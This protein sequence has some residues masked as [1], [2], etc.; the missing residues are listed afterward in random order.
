[1]GLDTTHN[2]WHGAYS[3][4]MRWREAVCEVAGYGDIHKRQGFG[5]CKPWPTKDALV[6][7]LNHSDCDGEIASKD[8]APLADRLEQLL[9]ALRNKGVEHAER[10][11]DFI[12]G[13]RLAAARGEDVEFR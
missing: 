2:C 12:K 4:F 5:G 6:I 13:L 7:L 1:M 11:E 8:C 3:S 9:P 10:A